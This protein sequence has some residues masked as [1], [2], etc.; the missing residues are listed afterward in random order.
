MQGRVLVIAGSDSIGGAGLEADIKTVTAL[1][2]YAAAAVT[3]LTAQDT[4]AVHGVLDVPA[5]FVRRQIRAVLDD[6]GADA[7]KTGLLARPD[8]IGAVVDEL[9]RSAKS[10][11]LVVDPVMAATTGAI[12]LD[13]ATAQVLKAELIPRAALLTPNRFEA[14]TLTGVKLV[15]EAD[16]RHAASML[17][18]LGPQAVLLKGGHVPGDT[19]RDYFVSP[20]GIEVFESRYVGAAPVHGAGCTL[21]SAIATGLAQGLDMRRAIVRARAYVRTAI[22][23]AKSYGKGLRLLHH[24]HPVDAFVERLPAKSD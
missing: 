1:G 18:T 10:V 17:L 21:A 12:F 9:D 20:A 7:I 23:Q 19:V 6:I 16:M 24:A 22:Q 3:A 8:V 15:D 14:E 2:G 5:E 11:P 13:P 4:R